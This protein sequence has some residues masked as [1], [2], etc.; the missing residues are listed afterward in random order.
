MS[1]A[2]Y[3]FFA[4]FPPLTKPPMKP[5][6]PPML[7]PGFHTAMPSVIP[8]LQPCFPNLFSLYLSLHWITLNCL[9]LLL[10][11]GVPIE[12]SHVDVF[13]IL[14]CIHLCISYIVFD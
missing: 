1:K 11:F 2:L 13:V 14:E 8:I 5:F 6:M 3:L 7:P 4:H 9:V 12:A 10:K